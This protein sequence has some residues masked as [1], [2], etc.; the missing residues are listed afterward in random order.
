MTVT[1]S[2]IGGFA[3]QFFD[4]NGVILSGGKIY[5]YAAGTTTPQAVYTSSSGATPHANPITLDSAG[6]VPGGE[7]WLTENLIYKFVIETSTAILIGTYDNVSNGLTAVFLAGFTAGPVIIKGDSAN[8]FRVQQANG[9]NTYVQSSL[10]TY[11]GTGTA[12]SGAP[13]IY[14]GTKTSDNDDSA[15]CVGR[16]VIGTSLFSHAFRDES[17]FTSNLD[18]AYT[19]FDARFTINSNSG[20]KY[21]HSYSFQA[22]HQFSAT[23]GIDLFAGFL[24]NMRVTAGTVDR[25]FHFHAQAMTLTGGAV[26]QHVG[27]HC[28]TLTGGAGTN[29]AFFAQTNPCFFG[30]DVQMNLGNISGFTEVKGQ[31]GTFTGSVTAFNAAGGIFIG[32]NVTASGYGAVRA[33]NDGSGAVRGLALNYTGGQVLIN[34]GSPVTGEQ[35]EVVGTIGTSENYRVDGVQ[36]VGNQGAAVADATD[37][38]TAITQL[39]ALLARLRTHGLIAT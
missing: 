24:S 5:T 11:S 9:T 28:G 12:T 15:V 19:G 33:Y 21:N 38:A 17:T 37:A 8:I 18:S 29:Y 7:I 39:N 30:G 26:L 23:N 3:A 31:V 6:R 10:N 20:A 22:S 16:A 35:L 32:G 36:V 1:P 13:R 25:L 2:P 27:F 4:N 14:M 34:A